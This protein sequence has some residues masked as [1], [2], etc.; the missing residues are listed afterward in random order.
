[1]NSKFLEQVE[2]EMSSLGDEIPSQEISIAIRTALND[3]EGV[4]AF[5]TKDSS[6]S[7]DDRVRVKWRGKAEFMIEINPVEVEDN[8][9]KKLADKMAAA[10]TLLSVKTPK[11]AIPGTVPAEV[12]KTQKSYLKDLRNSLNA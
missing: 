10:S 7:E 9:D 1:M 6:S 11:M 3:I 12:K 5:P 8:E 4:R 2:G